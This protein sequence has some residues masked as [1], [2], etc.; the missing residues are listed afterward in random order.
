MTNKQNNK[1]RNYII[2]FSIL[3][4]LCVVSVFIFKKK[5]DNNQ[6]IKIGAI[7]PLTRSGANFGLNAKNG[8]DMCIDEINNSGGING[9][10]IE[11]IE[12]DDE[13]DPA[14]A[15]SGYNFL[16][17]Q[18]VSAVIVGGTSAEALAIVEEGHQDN[19]PIM[20]TAASAENITHNNNITFKNVFRVGLT[21]SLQGEKMAQFIKDK[22][23][24]HVAVLYSSEDDYSSGVKDA[25][26][27]E[28]K[29][30]GIN[31]SR[32]ENFPPNTSDF[33]AQLENIKAKNPDFI[34]VPAYY[35]ADALIV[36]QA[37]KLEISCPIVGADGWNGI[38]NS[39]SDPSSLNNCYFCGVF[40]SDDPISKEFSDEHVKR[41]G[42][43][44]NMF[45][46]CSYDA[47][48][49]LY[50]ALRQS[51]D[52]INNLEKIIVPDCISGTTQF[53]EY[54]NP[55]KQLVILQIK[56]GEEKFYGRI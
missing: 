28:C 31:V 6:S 24:N 8:I 21:N 7:L 40:A 50:S 32:I 47:V 35:E 25:F 30:L 16:K 5:S 27:K 13:G 3:V 51:G 36:Q 34:F 11:C 23:A 12:F 14:K 49:I 17:D 29:S 10:K 48:K 22:K 54:H 15:V 37:R 18:G 39:A 38:T 42:Q 20:I 19:I 4:L 52:V 56:D 53:D 26:V 45:S 43:K 2:I 55:K 33:N 1:K 9:K 41:F 44:A 46:A